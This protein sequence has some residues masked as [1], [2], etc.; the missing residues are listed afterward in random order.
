[1]T[2]VEENHLTV[3][4][5]KLQAQIAAS[6]AGMAHFAATGPQ[7]ATCRE[8]KFWN[9]TKHDYHAKGGKH[10][11]AIKDVPCNKYRSLM[12]GR[13]GAKVPASAQAC[14]YFDRNETPP[15]LFDKS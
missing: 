9:H 2:L 14:K 8:C 7:G 5:P 6:H 4:N 10:R 11:G 15:L 13:V 1:M 12:G 3:P